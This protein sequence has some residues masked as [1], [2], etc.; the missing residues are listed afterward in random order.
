MQTIVV[1]GGLLGLAT[2][3]ALLDRG[4]SVRVIEAREGAGLETSF[5]NGGMLTPSLPEP[6]NGPGVLAALI[7]SVIDPGAALKL[8]LSVVPSLF[9][10][11]LRFVANSGSREHLAVSR[12][13]FRL[14]QYSLACTL[15][16]TTR[17]GLDYGLKR[18]GTICI[19][20]EWRDASTRLGLCRQLADLGLEM[21][22]LDTDGVIAAEPTLLPV[23]D[24]IACGLRLPADAHGDAHQ[25]CRA[26][27]SEI[28]AAGGSIDYDRRVTAIEAEGGAVRGVRIGEKIE[29]AERVIIAAGARSPALLGTVGQAIAVQPAKG[30]SLTI[31]GCDPAALPSAAICDDSAHAVVTSFGSRLRVAGTAEFAG[32]DTRLTASRI[33]ILRRALAGVLPN[34][35]A[36]LAPSRSIPWAGLRPLSHD[37]R[38]FIGPVGPEG[39]FVNT[40]HGALG[41]TMAVGSGRMLADFICDREPEVDHRP[42]AAMR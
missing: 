24:R 38:P 12:D 5:A 19:F 3:H 10:W 2:A 35:E 1:G 9:T 42:F 22:E 11:G 13:N 41:W 32:F 36:R 39:L 4:E 40:G 30:Y 25:F 20:A 34:L 15:E 23:R 31:E 33:A 14:A 6:W 28:L 26:L 7:R 17:L 8:R 18:S 16:L 21:E 27:V 37:G 29:Q